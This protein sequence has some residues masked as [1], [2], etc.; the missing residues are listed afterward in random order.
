MRILR[1]FAKSNAKV[2]KKSTNMIKLWLH[3]TNRVIGD[4]LSTEKDRD[5]FKETKSYKEFVQVIFHLIL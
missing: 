3:E 1:G 2:I 5:R 4:S